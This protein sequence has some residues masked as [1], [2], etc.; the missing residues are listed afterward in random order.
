M[1][2][3]FALFK[4][5]PFGGLQRDML[6]IA[7]E[8][9][10]RGHQVTVLC[11]AWEGERPDYLDITLLPASG[12]SNHRR[13]AVFAASVPAAADA[14]CVERVV[15]FNK[16]PGLDIYY[17]A[18][19]CFAAKVAEE[20][21][22]YYGLTPRA[23]QFMRM[24]RA[25]FA[26]DSATQI[27]LISAAE[28]EVYRRYYDTQAE[29]MH[30]LPPGIRRD[31]IMPTDYVTRRKAFRGEQG[32]RDAEKI[33]LFVGSG[34]RTKGLDRAIR[35]FASLVQREGEARLYV[36]GHDKQEPFLA[37]ANELGVAEQVHFLGGVD[38]VVDYLWGADVLLHPAY[39][40]NTGTVL[41]EAMVAGLPVVTTAACGYAY[42]VSE[43][44]MGEVLPLA[45]QQSSLDHAL[46]TV[47]N[48]P[49]EPWRERGR[50]FAEASDIFS[51]PERAADFIVG[52]A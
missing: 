46:H 35:A 7:R 51:M 30:L 36:L 9:V 1:H 22:R 29:R 49:T 32:W 4:Y 3:G 40:E 12:L 26:V 39:R 47:L 31:R 38:N 14:A 37:L 25:V 28:R 21:S 27:L 6:A 19:S 42:Y 13:D 50:R 15:G 52:S 5:F 20:R 48:A 43:A 44:K 24:E 33:V 18:D 23:R 41:L 10:N 11:S 17:A 34:F 2:L 45:M 8:C 16:M